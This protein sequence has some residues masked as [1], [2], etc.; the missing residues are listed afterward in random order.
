MEQTCRKMWSPL[1]MALCL[2]LVAEVEMERVTAQVVGYY[3]LT[4]PNAEKIVT[5]VVTDAFQRNPTIAPALLRL[6]F[7]DC[8]VQ[9]CDAS[10][11]LDNP[12]GEKTAPPNQSLRGFEVIDDAKQALE[13]ACPGIVSCADIVALAARDAVVLTGGPTWEV[14][15]GRMDGRF[16]DALSAIVNIPSPTMPTPVLTQMF[17]ANGLS[18]DEMITLSGAHTIGGAHCSSF[19]NRLS[20]NDPT[21]DE[22]YAEELLAACPTPNS[23]NV[24]PLDPTT[25]LTFDNNFFTNL[26]AGRGLLTSDQ[27]LYNNLGSE[28]LSI[29]DSNNEDLWRFK[30]AAAMVRLSTVNAKIGD[31]GEVRKNC[32]AVN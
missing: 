12:G 23:D 28:F 21:L 19:S 32:R 16:S 25:P 4:C 5:E 17:L 2:I 26:A 7:H 30:F 1:L 6:L 13:A 27:D 29:M 8:F 20:M 10:I 9:G 11:L 24:V 31:D 3:D 14:P 18:P 15:T 22:A